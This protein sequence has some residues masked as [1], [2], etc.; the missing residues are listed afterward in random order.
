LFSLAINGKKEVFGQNTII[1]YI[2]V[3]VVK[4]KA[5]TKGDRN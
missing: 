4:R 5:I 2:F 3:I 1:D